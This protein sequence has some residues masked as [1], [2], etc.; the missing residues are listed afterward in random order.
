[1]VRLSKDRGYVEHLEGVKGVFAYVGEHGLCEYHCLI[2][3]CDGVIAQCKIDAPPSSTLSPFGDH[4]LLPFA[5]MRHPP[6]HNTR[7]V[8]RLNHLIPILPYFSLKLKTEIPDRRLAYGHPA[9]IGGSK[10]G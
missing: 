4:F 2:T 9:L 3:G 8:G 5:L 1:M 6:S 10:L 7:A